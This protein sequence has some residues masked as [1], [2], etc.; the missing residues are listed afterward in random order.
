M[1]F[2][3]FGRLPEGPRARVDLGELIR[4][5]ARSNA[6]TGLAIE[7]DVAP[8]TPMIDGYFDAL[9]R[10]VS[11]LVLNAVDACDATGAPVQRFRPAP[12]LPTSWTENEVHAPAGYK[13]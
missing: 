10:A 12:K 11:N 3:Q 5:A 9:T 7:V 2:A 1:F 13:N 8:N 4:Y 6:S